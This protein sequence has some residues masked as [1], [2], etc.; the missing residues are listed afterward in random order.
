MK[1]I[2]IKRYSTS[3]LPFIPKNPSACRVIQDLFMH[4]ESAD[5]VFVR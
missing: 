3:L 4:E 2:K 1:P 5:V